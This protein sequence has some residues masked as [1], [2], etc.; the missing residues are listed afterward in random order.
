MNRSAKTFTLEGH[1]VMLLQYITPDLNDLLSS[2][3]WME[4]NMTSTHFY[5]KW[6][7]SQNSQ[8]EKIDKYDYL[9]NI[10]HLLHSGRQNIFNLYKLTKT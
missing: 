1:K 6:K 8:T 2:I 9:K 5:L 3:V 10:F 7:Q 4:L